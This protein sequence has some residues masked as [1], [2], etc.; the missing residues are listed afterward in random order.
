MDWK[1]RVISVY[2]NKK[3][4]NIAIVIILSIIL[5]SIIIYRITHI[6]K[7]P[8]PGALRAVICK[9]CRKV[10]VRRVY[11]IKKIKCKYCGGDVALAWKC[12]KCQYEYYVEENRVD[13]SKLNTMQRFQKVVESQKCPNCGMERNTHPMTIQEAEKEL[14]GK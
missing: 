2:S 12:G 5:F 11:D 10:D 14:S 6:E 4:R 13:T 9:K 1:E 3:Q 7:P 8:T